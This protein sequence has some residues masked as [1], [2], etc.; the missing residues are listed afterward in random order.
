MVK[1]IVG[2]LIV[3]LILLPVGN[4]VSFESK[5][6]TEERKIEVNNF[7]FVEIEKKDLKKSELSGNQKIE[8]KKFYQQ[9]GF[10]IHTKYN[11]IEKDS[12]ILDAIFNGIDIDNNPSTGVN[13]KDVRVSVIILPLIQQIDIGWILTFSIA[14]KVIRMGEELKYGDF[15]IYFKGNIFY[16]VSHTFKVGYYSPQNEE[17]PREIREVVTIVPYIFYEKNPEFYINLEPVFEDGRQN[18]SVIMEYSNTQTHKVIIDYF[19]AVNSMIKISPDVSLK[20]LNISIERFADVEQTIKMRY[21]DNF[22]INITVEDIPVRMAFTLGF[23]ENYFEYIASDEF[24][25]SLVIE[26][27]GFEFCIKLEYLPRHLIANFGEGYIYVYINERKTKF[28]VC[29]DVDSPTNY[30]SISNLTGE[31]TIQWKGE[32]EGYIIVEGFKGLKLE[33]YSE[34]SLTHFLLYSI[35]KAEYFEIKWNISLHGYIFIDTNWEW[36]SFYSL[37]ITI[38]DVFGVLIE[39]NLLRADD[40]NVAWQTVPPVFQINGDIDFIGDITFS[41]MLNGIW[42][43]VF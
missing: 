11:G 27:G 40:F 12:T 19:P 23:S 20:K 10:S 42:Y 6:L 38:D 36:L 21:E 43:D 30:L 35:L 5:N 7:E 37:N 8:L 18:L 17:I 32:Q 1:K 28:T 33:I 4:L 14:L 31:A 13:G 34:T 25:A 41:I 29:N 15:E 24:N 22:G 16:S 39:S 3:I 26:Y 2:I 9:I